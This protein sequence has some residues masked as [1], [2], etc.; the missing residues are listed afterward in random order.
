MLNLP[1][2]IY[3]IQVL[4]DWKRRTNKM[5]EN[6]KVKFKKYGPQVEYPSGMHQF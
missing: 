3:M 2:L 1:T 6:V 4:K 5:Q